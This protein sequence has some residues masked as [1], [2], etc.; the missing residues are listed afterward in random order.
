MENNRYQ[1]AK[2]MRLAGRIIEFG[3]VG[4]GGSMLIGE[5][6][7]EFL[8]VGSVPLEPAGVLLAV[9]GMVALAG[10]ILSLVAGTNSRHIISSMLG[11]PGCPHRCLCR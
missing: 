7:S 6:V 3:M 1:A 9:I 2:R 8:E 5:A 10:L 4:F 11:N